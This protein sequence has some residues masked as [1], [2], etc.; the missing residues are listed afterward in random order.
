MFKGREESVCLPDLGVLCK[1]GDKSCL[2]DSISV[3]IVEASLALLPLPPSPV[4]W[5][6]EHPSQCFSDS[7]FRQQRLPWGP[8]CLSRFHFLSCCL[9]PSHNNLGELLFQNFCITSSRKPSLTCPWKSSYIVAD[10]SFSPTRGRDHGCVFCPCH[11]SPPPPI[12][13]LAQ[14][15][16]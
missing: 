8:R 15:A 10:R 13:G 16:W 9:S 2:L 5:L 3:T 1:L 11:P 7:G 4:I 14:S 12:R 6:P